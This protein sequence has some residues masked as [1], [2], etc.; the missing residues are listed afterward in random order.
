MWPRRASTTQARASSAGSWPVCTAVGSVPTPWTPG[1]TPPSATPRAWCCSMSYRAEIGLA[2]LLVVA[3]IV[4]AVAGGR[5]RVAP[6][7][8]DPRTSTYLD[9]P[10]GTKAVYDVLIALGRP[11]TRR[12]TPLFDLAAGSRRAPALV[13]VLDP[14]IALQPAERDAVRDFVRRGRAVLAAGGGGG[15]TRCSGWQ[16]GR[17]G[18]YL[19]DS[20]AGRA[21]GNPAPPPTRYDL[22]PHTAPAATLAARTR[23]LIPAAAAGCPR[24]A[25]RGPDPLL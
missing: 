23:P 14:A 11:V 21:P 17:P 7:S 24:V 15:L 9:G 3:L 19:L 6:P 1:S 16:G 2:A 12:R 18:R 10:L 5:Q 4:A 8:Y 22:A 13:A 20:M 25:P